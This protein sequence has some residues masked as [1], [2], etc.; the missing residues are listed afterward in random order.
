MWKDLL[1]QFSSEQAGLAPEDLVTLAK[2]AFGAVWFQL[3]GDIRGGT[4]STA[5]AA[6]AA[7]TFA[8]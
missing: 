7:P 6:A 3:Y 5:A 4:V 2:V 8:Q 1:Q